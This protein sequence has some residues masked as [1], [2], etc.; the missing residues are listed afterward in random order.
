MCHA[1]ADIYLVYVNI[2]AEHFVEVVNVNGVLATPESM[3]FEELSNSRSQASRCFYTAEC[4]L[5]L[6]V[7]R[8]LRC[9][10][11]ASVFRTANKGF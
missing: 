7:P 10:Y 3:E 5:M 1:K 9:Q 6:M 4:D 11:K 8:I 2:T